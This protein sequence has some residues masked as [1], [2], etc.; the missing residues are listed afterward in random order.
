[1]CVRTCACVCA[2]AHPC[3]CARPAHAASCP[4]GS[5]E[6]DSCKYTCKPPRSASDQSAIGK[7]PLGDSGG[8]GSVA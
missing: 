6:H 1:M 3:T 2:C 8:G 5:S 4:S 7:G